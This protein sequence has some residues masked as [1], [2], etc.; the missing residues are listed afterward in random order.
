MSNGVLYVAKRTM[1]TRKFVWSIIAL[2]LGLVVLIFGFVL[3]GKG[4]GPAVLFIGLVI[5]VIAG[6]FALFIGIAMRSNTIE[7]YEK[8]YIIKSGIINKHED[9]ALLTNLISVSVN[10]GLG[11]SLFHYGTVRINVVGKQDIKLIGVKHPHEL[12]K[13]IQSLMEKTDIN[14]IKQVIQD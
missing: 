5:M 13:Y 10:Q 11:G 6:L 1:I 7:F 4:S 14:N 2:I 9:E 8:K 3:M 12:K